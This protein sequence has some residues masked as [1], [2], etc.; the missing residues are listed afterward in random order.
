MRDCPMPQ[1]LLQFRDGKL[2]L[3][4]KQEQAQPGRIGQKAKEIN[5]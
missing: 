5:G 2:F 3:F 4:E 1:D